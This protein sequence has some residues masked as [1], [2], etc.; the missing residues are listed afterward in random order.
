M[1][2]NIA[3]V[4]GGDSGEIEVS[5]NSAA[6]VYKYL[7]KQRYRGYKIVITKQAWYC[8][9]NQEKIPVDKNDFSVTIHDEKILFDCVFNVIHGTPGE[10]GILQGYFNLLDIPHTSS[11]VLTSSLTFNK[12]LTNIVV[13]RF[14][15]KIAE[16]V[17]LHKDEDFSIEEI[18]NQVTLPCFVK[19]NKGGSSI[20]ITKVN[21]AENLDIAIK[22][23]LKEDDEVMVEEFIDGTEITCGVVTIGGETTPLPIT[24]IVTHHE[25]FNYTAKYTTGEADE[26]TPARISKEIER[27]CK[28][29]SSKLYRKLKCKGMVRFDYI[30]SNEMLYFL[31]ANTVPGLS[32][33]SIVPQQAREYGLSNQ[34]LFTLAIENAQVD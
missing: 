16:S 13:K 6:V 30:W 17:V 31:E 18:L 1:K 14:G 21:D 8:E 22:T 23:A 9:W 5:F 7:D 20:G 27:I 19:P 15:I 2:K 28:N 33:N 11:G 32:E 25:F 3:I 12:E 4:C 24:E 29:T 26:I 10:D 34:E